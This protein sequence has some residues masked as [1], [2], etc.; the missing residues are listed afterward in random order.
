M[1]DTN[2]QGVTRLF[3]DDG[4]LGLGTI[5]TSLVFLVIIIGLV[6]HLT[7]QERKRPLESTTD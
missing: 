7:T 1:V 6:V 2:N 5:S 3:N 4:G